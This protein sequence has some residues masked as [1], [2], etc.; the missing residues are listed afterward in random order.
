MSRAVQTAIDSLNFFVESRNAG[1][2]INAVTT[3]TGG[4]NSGDLINTAQRGGMFFITVASISVNTATLLLSINAKDV[5]SGTY[6]PYAQIQLG[7]LV[8]GASLQYS[9]LFY[10]GATSTPGATGGGIVGTM[11][12]NVANFGLP[13][14]GTFQVVS[15]LAVTTTASQ[16]GTLS[17]SV[18]YAKVM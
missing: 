4:A 6:F 14:P 10:V 12:G 3:A 7:S 11:S 13:L 15:S 1:N 9:A 8:P 18:D 16:T 2:I 17:Y 5:A